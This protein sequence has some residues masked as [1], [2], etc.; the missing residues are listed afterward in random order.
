M[1]PTAPM[2]TAIR[3]LER[4][5]GPPPKP[6]PVD[7]FQQVVWENVA[8]LADDAR[9]EK[10]FKTLKRDVGVTPA[11]ILHASLL[12][13]RS[14]TSLGILA[15]RFAGKLREAARVAL[16]EFD[17]DVGAVID[18][19]LP[20]ARRALKRFPGIGEPGAEKIL[21][22]S[23]RH[24]LLAPDSNALRVLQ[25]L[26]IVP[27]RKSY[28]AAYAAARDV[29]STQLGADTAGMQRAHQLFRRH[30]QEVCTRSAPDCPR[31]PLAPACPRIGVAT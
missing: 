21:L 1:A 22:F 6:F 23:G 25:R 2:R 26:G 3:K 24:A 16:E 28:S 18:L 31:C 4:Y 30:G 20:Q 19:P 11:A 13:L 27:Q 7:P 9:R 17:G 10:A 8:Y 15:E 12:Q 29:A 14:A 5:Y